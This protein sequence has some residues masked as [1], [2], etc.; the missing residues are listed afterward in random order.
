MDTIDLMELAHVKE[1]IKSKKEKNIILKCI[2]NVVASHYL[3]FLVISLL[4][5]KCGMETETIELSGNDSLV[6]NSSSYSIY[7]NSVVDSIYGGLNNPAKI[8]NDTTIFSPVRITP[9]GKTVVLDTSS[10]WHP[11]SEIK[12]Y[13]SLST[14]HSS[15]NVTYNL[16]LDILYRC[17]SGEFMR[18]E[19]EEGMWQAGFR[20]GEG[21]GIWNRDVCY[22]G[23]WMGSFFDK[24]V[25]KKSIEYVTAN[26]IDNGEDGLALPAIAVWNHFLVTGDTSIIRNTYSN[27]KIQIQ[28]IKYDKKRNLGFAHSGSFL[29][30]GPQPEAGGFPLSTNIL[31]AQAY[32]VMASMGK[33]IGESNS[34]IKLWNDRYSKMKETINQEYWN[35]KFGYFT[36]GPKGSE[37]YNKGHWENLGQS[38]AL[39]PQWNFAENEKR[40][41]VLNNVE[42]V[43]NQYGFTD[44]NYVRDTKEMKSLHGLQVWI[45]TEVGEMAAM[46]SA[47]RTDEV[48][49]LLSSAIRTATIHKSFYECVDWKTGEAWRYAGQLWHAMG[50]LSM[51]HYGILGMEYDETGLTF[52]NA[53]V[54]KPLA[55]LTIIN[56]QYRK[57]IFDISLK[58]WGIFDK[59]LLD[60]KAVDSIDA[61]LEGK[62][63]IEIL[64]K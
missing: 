50:F 27:L 2:K 63:K 29:D 1:F 10:W 55:N 33:I 38:L 3:T 35:E 42:S 31:Y 28:K 24:N 22:T 4:F 62:H 5:V 32:K 59:L 39:W 34:K 52:S 17:S 47:G 53:C 43:H 18:Y 48:L 9:N 40:N 15:I 12:K 41:T 61:K 54:P 30:S 58:G 56:F 57:A 11:V 19:G 14:N 49:E 16:A 46:A 64:L 23:L 8:P 37:S 45:F 20:R 44:L 13:P 51:V 7:S 6:F 25:A 36:L 60:G 26:G 21:Y